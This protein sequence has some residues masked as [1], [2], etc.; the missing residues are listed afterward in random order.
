MDTKTFEITTTVRKE[1]VQAATEQLQAFLDEIR[2]K[3]PKAMVSEI[4]TRL[5]PEE[6]PM[7]LRFSEIHVN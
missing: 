2:E 6:R 7:S 4:T 3:S 5:A 1:D